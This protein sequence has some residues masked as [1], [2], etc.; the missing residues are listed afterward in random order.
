MLRPR[1]VVLLLAAPAVAAAQGMPPCTLQDRPNM[2]MVELGTCLD[3]LYAAADADLNAAYRGPS[4]ESVTALNA[5]RSSKP[6]AH[7]SPSAT[8]RR[9]CG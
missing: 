6:S 5:P 2:S 7:G 9:P 4:A 3:S 8:Q 1:L